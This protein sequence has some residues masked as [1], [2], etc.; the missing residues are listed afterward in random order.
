[1]KL[2]ELEVGKPGSCSICRSHSFPEGT[3]G[4]RRP[5]P[6]RCS[7]TRGDEGGSS[8]DCATIGND[9]QAPLVR[10]PERQHSLALRNANP[11]MRENTLREH[12][13]DPIAC[14]SAAGVDDAPTAMAAFEAEPFVELDAEL[15]EI[16]NSYRRLFGE[17]L[18]CAPAA[19]STA[20]A[21]R[22]LGMKRWGIVVSYGCR[23][24]TLGELA[25]GREERSLRENEHVALGGRAQGRDEPGDSAADDDETECFGVRC[26]VFRAHASFSL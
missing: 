17:H 15:D 12:P 26:A 20:S 13:S 7:P 24:P 2:H 21:N 25:V 3:G 9:T 1:M 10:V 6:E 4:I 5:L 14:C 18:Y 19:E 8:S 16:A 11:R 22:V 23:N